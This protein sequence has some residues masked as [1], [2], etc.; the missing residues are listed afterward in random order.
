MTYVHPK[1]YKGL[2]LDTPNHQAIIKEYVEKNCLKCDLFMGQE[3]DFSECDRRHY[4]S[5]CTCPKECR[6]A[7]S[8]IDPHSFIECESL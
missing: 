4:K 1:K 6:E 8:L 3:H 5:S 7:V 2:V